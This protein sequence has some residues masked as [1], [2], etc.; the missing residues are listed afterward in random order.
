MYILNIRK[1]SGTQFLCLSIWSKFII[2]GFENIQQ[3]FTQDDDSAQNQKYGLN[4]HRLN[5]SSVFL[6][7]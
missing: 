4:Y 1:F 5:L 2:L 6:Y 3:Y 7:R